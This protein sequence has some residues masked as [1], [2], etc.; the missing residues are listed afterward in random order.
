MKRYWKFIVP[1][2]IVVVVLVT[3]VVSLNSSLVYFNTPTEL[4]DLD[5]GDA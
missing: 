4:A 3:L 2:V 1:A 5:P